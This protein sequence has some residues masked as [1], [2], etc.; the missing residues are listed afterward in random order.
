MTPAE[1]RLALELEADRIKVRLDRLNASLEGDQDA[2]LSIQMRMPETVAEV[3][4]DKLLS[5]ARQQALALATIVK[6]LDGTTATEAPA[7]PGADPAD[8]MRK[9]REQKRREAAAL[10]AQA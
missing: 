2:W 3:V 4:V 6:A 8:E 1:R 7:K 5:E 10:A 9:K